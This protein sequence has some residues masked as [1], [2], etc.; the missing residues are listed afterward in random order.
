[1]SEQSGAALAGR[2]AA[3]NTGDL[4]RLSVPE[5]L[6]SPAASGRWVIDPGGSRAEFA[7]KQFWGTGTVRGSFGPV[8]GEGSVA[9][10]GTVSAALTIDVAS[11]NTNNRVRDAHLRSADFFDVRHHPDMSV[12]VMA[13]RP[14][15][16]TMLA[17]RGTI[18]AAGRV[19]PVEF[20][21]YVRDVT[22]GAVVLEAELLVDRTGFAMT[23]RPLGVAS[24]TAR[25]TVV[26]RFTRPHDAS[27]PTAS[28]PATTSQ[29]QQRPAT[30]EPGPARWIQ[31]LRRS[32]DALRALVEQF[33]A[34]QLD[35]QS[36]AP[37]WS[38]AQ[39]LSH[40]GSQAE[41]FELF[42][43]AALSGAKPPG[44]EAF[45]PIWEIWNAKSAQAQA[46]ESLAADAAWLERME[47]FDDAQLRLPLLGM[48]LDVAG[49]ARKR[50][51][52]HAQH[53]WDI[54]VTLDPAATLPLEA[55]GLLVDNLG[56][57]V[58]RAAK[59]D[60]QSRRWRVHTSDPERNFILETG[61]SV[62][63]TPCQRDPSTAD[64]VLPAE[65]LIRLVC[66]QLDPDHTPAIEGTA[67]LDELRTIFPG[68]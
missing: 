44:P 50:L 55:A 25:G 39:V 48:D 56:Q 62:T 12:T 35:Q 9:A 10:D 57:L 40:L 13:A 26:A 45:G 28:P 49:L 30:I 34:G 7:V 64:L 3:A 66:G 38:I 32:H 27:E 11:L 31:A 20:T 65:A 21:A 52:E 42:L 4:A 15:G 5:M 58:G 19:Q 37:D 54:A 33:D 16:P 47:S 29:Q 24:A 23:W 6:A 18:A 59:P 46:T 2:N 61:E 63:L 43:D 53:S 17:C 67:N 14:A 51:S 41:I 1:M 36:Y 68:F 22:E 8:S 60:G